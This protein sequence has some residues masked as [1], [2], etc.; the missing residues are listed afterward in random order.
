VKRLSQLPSVPTLDETVMPGL[1]VT[2]WYGLCAP[3][4]TPVP[5]LEK[6]HADLL[7]IL[8]TQDIQER[9]REMVL[10]AAPVSREQFAQFI[11]GEAARWAKVIK[12]AG[13]AQQ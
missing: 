12:A 9:F 6:V 3:A 10:D 4:G 1:E 2:T 13:I 5:I 7:T 11:K 8:R